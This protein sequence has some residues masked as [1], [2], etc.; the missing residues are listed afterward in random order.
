MASLSLLAGMTVDQW[1]FPHK[2]DTAMSR[3][4]MVHCVFGGII[5]YTHILSKTYCIS[6]SENRLWLSKQCRIYSRS[7]R[8]K[9]MVMDII[10]YFVLEIKHHQTLMAYLLLSCQPRVTVTKY[11]IYDC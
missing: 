4:D 5:G 6:F 9:V 1:T 10:T 11:F 2:F 8:T 3:Y 7:S